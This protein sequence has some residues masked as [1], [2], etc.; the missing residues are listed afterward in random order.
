AATATTDAA[1]GDLEATVAQDLGVQVCR[2]RPWARIQDK[3]VPLAG[4][5]TGYQS[6]DRAEG[7]YIY[8]FQQQVSSTAPETE[9][10]ARF[11]DATAANLP[12]GP[13]GAGG[14]GAG[15]A[16]PLPGDDVFLASLRGAGMAGYRYAGGRVLVASGI[17]EGSVL[18]VAVYGPDPGR[19]DTAAQRILA[20]MRSTS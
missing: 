17:F 16:A 13:S 8:R 15:E 18:V 11:R 1:L 9:L 2:P 6:A 3:S 4:F 5:S 20:S 19:T 14:V 10:A 7:F 12:V